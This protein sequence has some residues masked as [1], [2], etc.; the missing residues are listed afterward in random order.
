MNNSLAVN[1][2]ILP[3]REIKDFCNDIYNTDN[4]EYSSENLEYIPHITLYQKAIKES[5][6]KKLIEKIEKLDL[7]NFRI[8]LWNFIFSTLFCVEVKRNESITKLQKAI[9]DILS[10]YPN[11]ELNKES[12]LTEK[13]FFKDNKN[14]VSSYWE[15]INFNKDLHITLWKEDQAGKLKTT[16]IPKNFTFDTLC[17]GVMWNYCSVRKIIKKFNI[18]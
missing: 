2:C 3:S 13:Y 6:I 12:F 17:I 1:I 4:S 5:D 15:Y 7:M 16:N 14:W 11:F 10:K 9:I 8:E 18:T